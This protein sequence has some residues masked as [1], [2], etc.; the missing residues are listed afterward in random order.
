MKLYFNLS[1]HSFLCGVHG[2]FVSVLCIYNETY[3]QEQHDDK[4]WEKGDILTICC[5]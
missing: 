5:I 1:L 3:D 2:R 4:T